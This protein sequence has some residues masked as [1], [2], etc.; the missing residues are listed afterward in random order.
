MWE[1][2]HRGVEPFSFG[3]IVRSEDDGRKEGCEWE[4]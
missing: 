1:R 3:S 2:F 4:K